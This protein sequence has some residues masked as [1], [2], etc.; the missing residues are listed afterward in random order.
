MTKDSGRKFIRTNREP[1]MV[2]SAIIMATLAVISLV[3]ISISIRRKWLSLTSGVVLNTLMISLA[4][5]GMLREL[6]LDAIPTVCFLMLAVPIM[7]LA[8]AL[9]LRYQPRDPNHSK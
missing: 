8:L 9:G 7:D 3:A 2:E 4:L 1:K 5:L 6:S